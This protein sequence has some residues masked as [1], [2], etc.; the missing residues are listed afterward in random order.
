MLS[1]NCNADIPK[2]AGVEDKIKA[3]GYLPVDKNGEIA[4][5]IFRGDWA[6]MEFLSEEGDIVA[7]HE[8]QD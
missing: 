4:K 7:V 3:R 6:C 1:C 8:K 5:K 2:A